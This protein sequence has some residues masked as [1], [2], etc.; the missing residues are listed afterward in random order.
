M[1]ITFKSFEDW[2]TDMFAI[3][4]FQG[5]TND[6]TNYYM[7]GAVIFEDEILENVLDFVDM[8]AQAGSAIIMIDFSNV[9]LWDSEAGEAGGAED[10]LDAIVAQMKEWGYRDLR[11]YESRLAFG[12]TDETDGEYNIRI[13]GF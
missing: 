1:Q 10:F 4:D 5:I 8:A 2:G 11:S 12:L 6:D 3:Q 13:A 7:A 9:G